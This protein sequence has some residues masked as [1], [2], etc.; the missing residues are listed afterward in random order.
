M[1]RVLRPDGL[2][3]L[4]LFPSFTKCLNLNP[5]IPGVLGPDDLGQLT[6][7]PNST[8]CLNLNPIMP[9]VLGQD[10]LGQLTLIF[11]SIKCLNLNSIMTEVLGPDDLGQLT[12][13][14]SFFKYLNLNINISFK[15]PIRVYCIYCY[16]VT[17]EDAYSIYA[18]TQV[19]NLF[20]WTY[21]IIYALFAQYN[22]IYYSN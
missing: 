12:L 20:S 22:H 21:L 8:K 14:L 7:F 11:S 18:L 9:R 3:Q 15:I 5:I 13:I 6:L 2:G 10:D 16:P 17:I 1:P 19:L 4:V